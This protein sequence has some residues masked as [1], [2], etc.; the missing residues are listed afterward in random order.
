MKQAAHRALVACLSYSS[1][2][3]MKATCFSETSVDFQRTTRRYT[4]RCENLKPY[5]YIV[6]VYVCIYMFVDCE[7]SLSIIRGDAL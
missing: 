3:K 1:S 6:R 7:Q 4:H 2:Q 5:T